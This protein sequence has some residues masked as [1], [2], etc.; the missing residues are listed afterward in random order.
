[1]RYPY[2]L[3]D[4]APPSHRPDDSA[5]RVPGPR[6]IP[7]AGG[8]FGPLSSLV[9][10]VGQAEW[11]SRGRPLKR[12]TRELG[13]KPESVGRRI[14]TCVPAGQPGAEDPQRHA[15]C[16]PM[17]PVRTRTFITAHHRGLTSLSPLPRRRV[18]A[19]DASGG[20]VRSAIS[21]SG[22]AVRARQ[23]RRRP[24]RRARRPTAADSGWLE[25][26]SGRTGT[27]RRW[28]RGCVM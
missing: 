20:R 28:C 2:L 9:T 22:A 18:R 24:G 16:P 8:A 1:M 23:H 6:T 19:R 27:A 21:V 13:G 3:S 7:P 26:L 15:D 11:D 4:L 25:P 10:E 14:R 5:G 12:L 17:K